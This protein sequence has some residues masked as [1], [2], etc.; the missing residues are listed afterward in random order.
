VQRTWRAPL[1]VGLV[2]GGFAGG[3]SLLIDT[4]DLAG[5]ADPDGA[6][7]DAPADA[8][9]SD[10][11][12]GDGGAVD[13]STPDASCEASFCD[14]FDELPLGGRWTSKTI[15]NGGQ[16]SLG[17]AS[18]IS[19]PNALHAFVEDGGAP[20]V[21]KAFVE[22]DLGKGSR[23]RCDFAAFVTEAPK[24]DFSDLFVITTSAQNVTTYK[25]L[26]GIAAGPGTFRDDVFYSDGGCDCP[27]LASGPPLLP[28]GQWV[29]VS[30]ETD[31]KTGRVTYDGVVVSEQP[32]APITPTGTITVQLGILSYGRDRTDVLYDDV[33]CTIWK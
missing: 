15:T 4:S 6:T 14:D 11:S 17:T 31:F 16:L 5:R 27:R 1:L 30:V 23:V 7:A 9:A 28:R 21:R 33:A 26:Y 2:S 32:T 10:T 29:R 22:R 18:T 19:A 12:N 8:P 25:L 24:D 3:C 20:A 13:G